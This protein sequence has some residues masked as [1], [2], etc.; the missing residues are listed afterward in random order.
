VIS[1]LR[2]IVFDSDAEAVLVDVAGV[3]YR[4]GTSSTTLSEL[5]AGSDVLLHTRL[6]VREDQMALYGFLTREELVLFDL[7]MGVSGIGPRIAC[8]ILSRFTPERLHSA[9]GDEDVTLLATVPGIGRKTAAR[10]IVELK[11][12]LPELGGSI[13]GT[14]PRSVTDA[15]AIEA[16]KSLGDSAAE[17]NVAIASLPRTESATV[18]ERVVE[19]LKSLG[20]AS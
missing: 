19:A 13:S 4:V 3:I 12:K 9:L 10:M 20:P 14:A 7:V 15:E 11:G 5:S 17:A 8:S 18:E 1:G 2:G 16:L 6:I